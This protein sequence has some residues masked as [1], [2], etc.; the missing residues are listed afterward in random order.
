MALSNMFR[1]PRREI[2]ETLLGI[3]IV[4]AFLSVDYAF[5]AWFMTWAYPPNPV[6]RFLL[7][8]F[9]MFAGPVIAG[10][11]IAVCVAVVT[12]VHNI[13]EGCCDMLEK[14][15]IYLRP[16]QQKSIRSRYYDL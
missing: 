5:A 7:L 6:P 12:S 4:G 10:C 13:G 14:R 15:N 8:F 11:L 3:A 16:R 9:G 1:E 2:T